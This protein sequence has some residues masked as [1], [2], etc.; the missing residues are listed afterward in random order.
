MEDQSVKVDMAAIRAVFCH[1]FDGTYV[2]GNT[3]R[4][5]LEY[6]G[7][8][9]LRSEELLDNL[10]LIMSAYKEKR[11]ECWEVVKKMT[12]I[13]EPGDW[14]KAN[15][16][17]ARDG[18]AQAIVSFN[19]F[20][21]DL[22]PRFLEE[23]VGLDKAF[24]QE[25]IKIISFWPEEGEKAD[26]SEH[27]DRAKIYA[28][29]KLGLTHLPNSLVVF[30]DDNWKN[31]LR[32]CNAQYKALRATNDGKHIP[33]IM[34]YSESIK[35]PAEKVNDE[36]SSSDGSKSLA[37]SMEGLWKSHSP[38]PT[39]ERRTG[40]TCSRESIDNEELGLK[41]SASPQVN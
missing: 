17:I 40:L 25:H 3:Q 9:H 22:F 20:G 31:Y 6:L 14:K 41:R 24:I 11:E 37:N 30:T 34:E 29:E 36:N 16:K 27:L 1:D 15:E 39:P 32:A 23:M 12:V 33:L 38:S 35:H 13:G 18:H 4:A 7:F 2:I 21:E 19:I 26:K 28:K 8:G 5:I 10:P